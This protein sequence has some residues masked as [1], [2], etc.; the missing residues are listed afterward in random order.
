M[1]I[2]MIRH[3]PGNGSAIHP[4]KVYEPYSIAKQSLQSGAVTSELVLFPPNEMDVSAFT[5]HVLLITL[6]EA[7]GRRLIRIDNQ[8]YE[9]IY[10]QGAFNMAPAGAPVFVEWE[11]TDEDIV[12]F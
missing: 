10:P 1:C 5:N 8:E 11:S 3:Q 9:G 7:S 6:S 12:F 4:I 2:S